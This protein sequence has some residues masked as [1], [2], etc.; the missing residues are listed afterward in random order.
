[1]V[2]L[3]IFCAVGLFFLPCEH[4]QL[5]KADKIVPTPKYGEAAMLIGIAGFENTWLDYALSHHMLSRCF[6]R[7]DAGFYRKHEREGKSMDLQDFEELI[8]EYELGS[9]KAIL[10]KIAKESI[11][12]EKAGK[13]TY[14]H[15]GNSRVS[16]EPDLP[17]GVSWPQAKDGLPMTFLAQL[18]LKDVP[19]DRKHL[20][21]P[22]EGVLYF[23]IADFDSAINIE[24][25]VIYVEDTQ[26]LVRTPAPGITSLEK[27]QDF[28]PN[29]PYTLALDAGFSV[30]VIYADEIYE[31][32]DETG[33][34]IDEDIDLFSDFVCDLSSSNSLGNMFGYPRE[35]HADSEIVAALMLLT[36]KE[37]NY[38]AD[39]GVQQIAN[40]IGSMEKA[41]EEVADIVTLLELDSDNEAGFCWGDAGYIHFFMRKEDVLNKNFD[42][43]YLSLYSS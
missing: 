22:Q 12:L 14:A 24:H 8:D 1:M 38:K 33:F 29:A 36:G 11:S 30:S 3:L 31:S 18:N 27:G 9:I 40:E 5:C 10:K 25:R 34:D 32:A 15:T 37:Y 26:K 35:Q 43:T 21:L 2:V 28:N 16:G 7:S 41:Q 17:P 39:E 23:F 42:K 4:D 20:P 13:E 6:M 19:A